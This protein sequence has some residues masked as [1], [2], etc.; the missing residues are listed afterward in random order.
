LRVLKTAAGSSLLAIGL[1]A[2]ANYGPPTGYSHRRLRS[3]PFAWQPGRELLQA[4][5]VRQSSEDAIF[6]GKKEEKIRKTYDGELCTVL[7]A[8]ETVGYASGRAGRTFK[9]FE[10][11]RLGPP[12]GARFWLQHSRL[13][14]K[15]V[16]PV[17]RAG[18]TVPGR[19]VIANVAKH[20]KQRPILIT[21]P[22]NRSRFELYFVCI[23]RSIFREAFSAP[24]EWYPRCWARWGNL[25]KP[26]L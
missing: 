18:K 26:F 23:I 15:G 24:H 2:R 6:R 8:D 7:Q 9:V 25:Y 21:A 20:K 5:F 12:L 10:L 11:G 14:L 22:F 1:V 3:R 4:A 13:S 16:W 19:G 17:G